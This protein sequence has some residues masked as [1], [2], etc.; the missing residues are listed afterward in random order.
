[1]WLG[2]VAVLIR[3]ERAAAVR[4]DGVGEGGVEGFL[5]EVGC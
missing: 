1:M 4:T 3:V 5:T 2:G